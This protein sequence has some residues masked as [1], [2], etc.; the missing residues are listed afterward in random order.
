MKTHN[1]Q[2]ERVKRAY[3]T[4]LAEAKGFSE[5]TLDGVA[6]ALNR[7]ET[8]TKFRDFKAFHIE[9][10]K[11]FKASL[12]AQMSLRTKDRLSK[13]TLYATLSALKRFFIWLAGQPGYK[14]RISYSD[15]EYFN[16]SAK[17][18]RIAKAH[19]DER[20]PTL[21]QIRCVI[22]MMPAATEIERRDRALIAFTILTGA[23]DGATAS[24]KLKHIDIDQGWVDQD[25]RQVKTKFSKSFTTWFFPVGDDIRQIVVDWI[26]YLRGEKLWGLNDPLFPATKIVVGDTRHFEV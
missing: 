21:E 5:A 11:G 20:V 15:A 24:L 9:Q 4:Y 3:F 6:K 19:R 7:F 26:V 2:N 1:P 8:Y 23:R 16:L 13:P 12:A 22:R 18:T 17:E 25:A 10:A 14:S